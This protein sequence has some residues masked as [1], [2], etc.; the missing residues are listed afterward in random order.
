MDKVVRQGG[1][2]HA[3]RIRLSL[4]MTKTLLAAFAAA[5]S[6]GAEPRVAVG[7]R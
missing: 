1:R 6:L 7:V 5:A 2:D 3:S 4:E